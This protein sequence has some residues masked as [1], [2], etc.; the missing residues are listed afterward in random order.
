MNIAI[1]TA[2]TNGYPNEVEP[3]PFRKLEDVVAE[4][5]RAINED[6]DHEG[7]TPSSRT[8]DGSLADVRARLAIGS[9]TDVQAAL[10]I[11]NGIT[12]EHCNGSDSVNKYH[13]NTPE[14]K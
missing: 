12:D 7:L 6:A 5:L 14:L 9:I 1:V 4:L 13:L 10:V 8:E 2:A 11:W 3:R